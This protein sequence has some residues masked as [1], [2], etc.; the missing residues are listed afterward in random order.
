MLKVYSDRYHGNIDFEFDSTL[1]HFMS[2]NNQF[3]LRYVL[4]KLIQ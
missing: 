4:I 3:R 1:R 2:V